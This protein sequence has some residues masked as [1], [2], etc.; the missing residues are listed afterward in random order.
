MDEPNTNP[1]PPETPQSA[2][3]TEAQASVIENLESLIKS[4]ITGIEK[5]KSEVKKLKDMIAGVLTNDETYRK[6]DENAKAAAKIRQ[7][8]K[9]ELMKAPTNQDILK[10]IQLLTTEAKEMDDA[11][12]DYL[13][14]FERMSGSNEIETSDG[15]V[16][17]IVYS[18]RLIKKSSRLK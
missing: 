16:R 12:S 2:E 5:R 11:L 18:A 9:S 17:E 1:A 8:T 13:R 15:E 14:E 7:Q 6:H 3:G 4:H 10:K